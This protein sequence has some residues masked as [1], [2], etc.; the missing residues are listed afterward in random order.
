MVSVNGK[1]YLATILTDISDR[2]AIDAEIRQLNASLESR[3]K[4]RTVELADANR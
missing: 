2:K 4:K 1:K 3:V